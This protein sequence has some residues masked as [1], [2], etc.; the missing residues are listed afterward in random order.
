MQVGIVRSHLLRGECISEMVLTSIQFIHTA[1]PAK[2]T[3][4]KIV[5]SDKVV[6]TGQTMNRPHADLVE[7]LEKVLSN[8]DGLLKTL[9]PDICHFRSRCSVAD[10]FD[11]YP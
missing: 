5:E 7:S 6:V 2:P 9:N 10:L 3:L 11:Y 4:G 8:S 1:D